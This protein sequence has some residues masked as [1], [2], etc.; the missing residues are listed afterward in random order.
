[1]ILICVLM[2]D[3]IEINKRNYSKSRVSAF[4]LEPS[5]IQSRF[6]VESIVRL[7]L[8]GSEFTPHASL[9]CTA[10]DW[11]EVVCK[12]PTS[13]FWNGSIKMLDFACGSGNISNAMKPYIKEAIG[14]DIS[15]DMITAYKKRTGFCGYTMDIANPS[16]K[17]ANLENNFD[18][19]ICTMAFHHIKDYALVTKILI[20]KLRPGGWIFI[21]DFDGSNLKCDVTK[22]FDII[23]RGKEKL[24]NEKGLVEKK[25]GVAHKLGLNSDHISNLFEICGLQNVGVQTNL[26]LTLDYTLDEI[27][28]MTGQDPDVFKDHLNSKQKLTVTS[29]FLVA[30]GMKPITV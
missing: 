18:A 2:L 10:T 7:N 29:S 14:I 19:V 8:S 22:L 3:F 11:E 21:V 30:S 26:N 13:A 27:A 6:Q 12:T 1:M 4:D 9:D 24:N 16:P 25:L 20:E 5:I 17:E 15:P 23:G 28:L